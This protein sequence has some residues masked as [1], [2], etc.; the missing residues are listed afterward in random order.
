MASADFSTI[1]IGVEY[2][3]TKDTAK[4]IR[5][6]ASALKR[7]NDVTNNLQNI[8]VIADELTSLSKVSLGRL[9]NQLSSFVNS[10]KQIG[11]IK[12]TEKIQETV[13]ATAQ[14]TNNVANQIVDSQQVKNASENVSKL[15][16]NLIG[17]KEVLKNIGNVGV[18]GFNAVG[19]KLKSI[20][21][22]GLRIIL[23]RVLRQ[24]ISSI[25]KAI[26]QGFK[27][28]VKYSD[29]ANRVMSEITANNKVI[30]NQIGAIA[31]QL[32][33]SFEP[34]IKN[35]QEAVIGVTNAFSQLFAVM[36]GNDTYDKATKNVEDYRASLQSLKSVGIDELNVIGDTTSTN[37]YETAEVNQEYKEMG[38]YLKEIKSYLTDI[39]NLFSKV[40]G[41]VLEITVD[42]FPTLS[43][44]IKQISGFLNK[45]IPII[46]PILKLLVNVVNIITVALDPIF[47]IL[48]NILNIF[49]QLFTKLDNG[50]LSNIKWLD[51]IEKVANV[52]EK[53]NEYIDNIFTKLGTKDFWSNL[54]AR[55]SNGAKSFGS[56][57][58][59]S[60]GGFPQTGQLFVAR[61][62]G[63]EL[64]G[65][66]G[67][68][69]A[70]ANN[71][72]IIQGIYQGVLKAM[73]QA[74]GNNVAVYLDSNE[75][76]SVMVKKN[77]QR[78][79]G[80]N[81]YKGGNINA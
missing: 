66:I 68:N 34:A 70:V 48:G 25:M 36:E 39:A 29:E 6:I 77:I 73:E 45:A 9:S 74:G 14:P 19:K 81:I 21:K 42:S 76:N 50:V 37:L 64:V 62:S 7:L 52:V 15:K 60:S 43:I 55:I 40:I 78:G 27:E 65:S 12:N 35:I 33:V 20:G 47:H 44:L 24:I 38:Q 1:K 5:A 61:E 71:D 75:I 4:S 23:Y 8:K 32:L 46:T 16:T 10:L 54:W 41:F 72:Q 30:Y 63:A 17:L 2:V 57:F 58:G 26:S 51:I 53:I 49:T 3:E 18:K 59:F 13:N 79:V 22:Q 31:G 56:A 28:Y 69:T 80:S 11:A 67:G